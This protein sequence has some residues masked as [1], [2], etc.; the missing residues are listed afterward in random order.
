[1]KRI[2]E[3]ETTTNRMLTMTTN[4]LAVKTNQAILLRNMKPLTTSNRTVE[5]VRTGRLPGEC[6]KIVVQY[7]FDDVLPAVDDSTFI[8]TPALIFLFLFLFPFYGSR[9]FR[10][11]YICLFLFSPVYF[12][13]GGFLCFFV[14]VYG[15][16]FFLTKIF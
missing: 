4:Q 5:E 8:F 14:R 2:T 16:V 15:C 9:F 6:Q 11:S 3:S 7:W 1:M 13:L 12:A 10:Y